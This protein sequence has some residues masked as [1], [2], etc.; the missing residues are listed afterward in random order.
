MKPE[1]RVRVARIAS[2]FWGQVIVALTTL[3]GIR[4]YTEI[5]G[6]AEFGTTMLVLGAVA[7]FDSFGVMA[8]NQTLLSRCGPYSDSEKRRQIS[9]GLS[10]VFLK[11]AGPTCALLTLGVTTVMIAL[12]YPPDWALLPALMVVY[13]VA[14]TGKSSLIN[15]IVLERRYGRYSAWIG[16]EAVLSLLGT[17]TALF[18]WRADA[19]GFLTG[20]VLSRFISAAVFI[21]AFSPA[22]LRSVD[23]VQTRDEIHPALIYGIPV[24]MMGPLGWISTY[25]DRY[26]LV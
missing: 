26:I 12:G 16:G 22:H 2:V 23:L 6:P 21:A 17:V 19:I 3:A 5:L 15:L 8:L 14:E 13:I 20:Y 25:L 11:W 24:A 9:V 1:L 10:W 18:V 7:L 4:I